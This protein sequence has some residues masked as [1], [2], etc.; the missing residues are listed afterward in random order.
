MTDAL[1]IPRELFLEEAP[2]LFMCDASDA[3]IPPG[4]IP[5]SIHVP[6]LGNGLPFRLHRVE[7]LDDY[8][9]RF[10][11]LQTAGNC[12]LIVWND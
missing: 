11:Y 10:H 6:G 1:T 5:R 8:V 3:R 7:K 12:R 4:A 2:H 9:D